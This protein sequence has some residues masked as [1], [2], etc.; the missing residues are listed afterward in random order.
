MTLLPILLATEVLLSFDTEDFTSPA[1]ADGVKEIAELCTREGVTAHFATVGYMAKALAE[2]GR[3]DVIEAMRPHVKVSHTLHHSIHP[4]NLELSDNEDWREAYSTILERERAGFSLI[5]H[6]TGQDRI[7][8]MVPGGDCD[9]YPL[10]YAAADMG[11]K[12]YLGPTFGYHLY[13]KAHF[14]NLMQIGYGVC[15]ELHILPPEYP[16]YKPEA[17]LDDLARFETTC[18]WAHPNKVHSLL[19]W[20][21]L[22]YNGRNADWGNWKFSPRR[23]EA[24]VKEYL[25][26][27][28]DVIRRIK[29]DPRFEFVTVFDLEKRMKPRKAITRGDLQTIRTALEREFEPLHEPA[30]WSISDVFQAV[31]LF[32]RGKDRYEPGKVY[33]FVETPK[34]VTEP[35]KVRR[36][37]LVAAAKALDLGTFLPHEI[38]VGGVKIGPADFLYAALDTLCTG[39]EE[40]AVKPRPQLNAFTIFPDL[41]KQHYKGSWL[42]CPDFEDRR[43]S[44]RLRLQNWTTR[45]E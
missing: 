12:F 38:D 24:D 6:I 32:L 27:M 36:A 44:D 3:G 41:A 1:D 33:G 17:L 16:E 30:S 8:A 40:V 15:F 42:H 21:G 10:F 20:D 35:V 11:A 19:F 14:S 29:A 7:L 13:R 45:Y 25:R 26:R 43:A 2:W 9:G 22:N 4:D 37:D 34:G 28:A 23:S 31:T 18:L 5:R 39:A